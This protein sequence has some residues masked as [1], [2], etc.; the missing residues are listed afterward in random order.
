MSR[1]NRMLFIEVMSTAASLRFLI[2]ILYSLFANL[3]RFATFL[4]SL[5]PEGDG[6]IFTGY[7]FRTF[8]HSTGFPPMPRA[9]NC[10]AAYMPDARVVNTGEVRITDR[11]TNYEKML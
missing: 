8:C 6:C 7:C 11:G 2:F 10:S 1:G 9:E 5:K 4:L 3:F